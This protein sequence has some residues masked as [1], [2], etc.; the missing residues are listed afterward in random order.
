[1]T[2]QE[3]FD[4]S[5]FRNLGDKTTLEEYLPQLIAIEKAAKDKS[6]SASAAL[7]EAQEYDRK[8]TEEWDKAVT[9]RIQLGWILDRNRL[10]AE[11]TKRWSKA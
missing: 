1:M 3:Q 7:K 10:M 5:I 9:E 6:Y 8:A 4:R 11:H 2:V